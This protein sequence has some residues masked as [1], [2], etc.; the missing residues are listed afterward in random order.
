ML[1]V[2]AI[3]GREALS[4]INGPQPPALYDRQRT[5][6]PYSETSKYLLKVTNSR[7]K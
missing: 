7:R 6:L 4:K 2:F 3:D 1:R 5:S